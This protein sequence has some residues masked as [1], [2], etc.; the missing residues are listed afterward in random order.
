VNGASRQVIPVVKQ[1]TGN[2]VDALL[3]LFDALHAIGNGDVTLFEDDVPGAEYAVRLWASTKPDYSV[4]VYNYDGAGDV[5]RV[6]RGH[7]TFCAIHRPEV[8][9]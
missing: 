1:A 8:V 3:A 6:I 9:S 7:Q 4:V 5:V 2:N